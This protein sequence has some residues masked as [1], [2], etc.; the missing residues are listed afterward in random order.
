MQGDS[1]A[2]CLGQGRV[3]ADVEEVII[4]LDL[5]S[6]QDNEEED[7]KNNLAIGDG[8]NVTI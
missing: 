1:N 8:E 5:K 7:K 3:E 4:T 6:N 2:M